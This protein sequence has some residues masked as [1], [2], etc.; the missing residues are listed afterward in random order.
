[1]FDYFDGLGS[2]AEKAEV[3]SNLTDDTSNRK[4]NYLTAR[5]SALRP[6]SY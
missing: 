4:L 5:M 1:M 3:A 2:D 6:R